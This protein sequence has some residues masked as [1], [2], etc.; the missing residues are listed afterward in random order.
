[1][2]LAAGV[3]RDGTPLYMDPKV[4]GS[5]Q[6]RGLLVRFIYRPVPAPAMPA[7]G[8][9]PRAVAAHRRLAYGPVPA[10]LTLG[11]GR[12]HTHI[13]PRPPG[14]IASSQ[15]S[16]RWTTPYGRLWPRVLMD[17]AYATCCGWPKCLG[18]GGFNDR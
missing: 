13:Q 18:R 16:R 2:I 3:E 9:P 5:E 11:E 14:H 10:A 1:M 7:A 17:R 8:G 15:V 6:S 4:P 12:P